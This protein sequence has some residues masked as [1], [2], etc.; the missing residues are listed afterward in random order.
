M[1]GRGMKSTLIFLDSRFKLLL[2]TIGKIWKTLQCPSTE[3]WIKKIWYVHTHTLS[4]FSL[5]YS[6]AIKKNDIMPFSATWR[7]LEIIKLSDLSQAKT[8]K[9]HMISLTHGI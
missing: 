9:Y 1:Y 6:S 4:L 7:D 3:E 2:F 5:E 8:D